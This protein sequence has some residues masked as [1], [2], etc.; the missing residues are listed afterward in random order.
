MKFNTWLPVELFHQRLCKLAFSAV[1][2]KKA[3]RWRPQPCHQ[4]LS[5]RCYV[6]MWMYVPWVTSNNVA[7]SHKIHREMPYGIEKS[8]PTDVAGLF[9][10]QWRMFSQARKINEQCSRCFSLSRN[11]CRTRSD[12]SP[13]RCWHVCTI[14]FYIYD[15]S[16][17]SMARALLITKLEKVAIS[18]TC[19]V[20][21]AS[22]LYWFIGD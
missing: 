21:S 7:F 15:V 13:I 11:P 14:L 20:H 10:A 4:V 3:S 2:L 19:F 22:L 1:A 6:H 5:R 18:F 9:S 8:D 16:G 12:R 17:S